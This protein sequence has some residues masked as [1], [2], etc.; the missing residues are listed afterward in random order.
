VVEASRGQPEGIEIAVVACGAMGTRHGAAAL[1]ANDTRSRDWVEAHAALSRLAQQRAALDAEE[2]RWLLCALRSAAHV[3][4]GFGSFSQYVEQLF[5]YKPRTT[6]EKL[7]VAEALEML[8]LVAGAL[9][10]GAVGWCAAR[11]LTRVAAPETEQAW[12]DAA[13]GK[14]QRELE[15]LVA[16]KAPGDGPEAPATESPCSR[17]LRFEVAPD[18]FAT[19][20][21]AMQRLQHAAG[22]RLDEDALLLAMARHV[23]GGPKDAGRSSYQISLAVCSTCGAGA[24]LAGGE[25]VPIDAAVVTMA[26]CDA[27]HLG[28]VLPQTAVP[29]AANE[30][31]DRRSRDGASE[32]TR[33][34]RT[35]ERT[36]AHR[37]SD[38]VHVGAQGQPESDAATSSTAAV[39]S[40]APASAAAP[41]PAAARA[42]ARPTP[43]ARQSIPPALR[44]AVLA[45]DQ[46]CRVPGCSH[47]T[48]VDVHHMQPRSE[49]GRN[50]AQNLLVLCS[51]HHRATHCGEL[52]IE[53][54][55]DGSV[56]FRHADGTAYGHAIAP[57]GIDTHTKVFSALRDLGFREGQVKGVLAE[58]R[59]DTSLAGAPVERLLREA[60][61][62]IQLR[63]R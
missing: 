14:T 22:G 54:D 12:L 21:A 55:R 61:C 43:R 49:G 53:R 10:S 26:A 7:R 37:C 27:Q 8:P 23:L 32:S 19:F 31:A 11:E 48:F 50:E 46:R 34:E 39:P 28:E 24:Q 30:N 2:G 57:Q 20:R 52:L 15:A 51:V 29:Q 62:R 47:A 58:L 1:P 60:L 59:T 18:T 6:Q 3:H 45:R 5:G 41:N 35:A 63:A 13:R 4:L 42:D 33:S 56:I 9:E 17:V 25:L 38:H 16:N 36:A 44:R 40:A